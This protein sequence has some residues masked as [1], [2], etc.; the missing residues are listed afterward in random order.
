MAARLAGQRRLFEDTQRLLVEHAAWLQ[1]G[2][3]VPVPPKQNVWHHADAT[4]PAAVVARGG[5]AASW[6]A[7]GSDRS[8]RAVLKRLWRG[9]WLWAFAMAARMRRLPQRATVPPVKPS[10][11]NATAVVRASRNRADFVAL[12]PEAGRALRL[13]RPGAYDHE[14]VEVRRLFQRYLPAPGFSVSDDGAVLVEDWAN[15]QVLQGLPA[16]RQVAVA[17][18][19]LDRYADLVAAERAADEGTEWEALP[20]LLD[21]VRLPEVLREPLA[22]PRVRRLLASGLLTPSQGGLAADDI[23]VD[24]RSSSWQVVDFDE[25]GWLPVWW[26]PVGLVRRLLNNAGPVDEQ[27]LHALIKALDRVW[28]AAGLDDAAGLT[29]QH[30]AALVVLRGPWLESTHAA[31]LSDKGQPAAPNADDFAWHLHQQAR[32]VE[33]Q[34]A[35]R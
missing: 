21:Q 9:M 17:V 31:Y 19:V 22:D 30:W 14:Y 5:K 8:G 23:L 29:P 35:R 10:R 13:A 1:P 34:L 7:D 3:W 2:D 26:D 28:A 32:T 33:A 15:G 11:S 18:E 6:V 27:S 4:L 12:E 25:A 24:E 16:Q 20:R